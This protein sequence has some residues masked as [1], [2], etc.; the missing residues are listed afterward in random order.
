MQ[1]QTIKR[2]VGLIARTGIGNLSNNRVFE[3]GRRVADLGKAINSTGSRKA[4][5]NPLDS[6]QRTRQPVSVSQEEAILRKIRSV[7]SDPLQESNSQIIK[8]TSRWLYIT[9]HRR[10]QHYRIERFGYHTN[11]AERSKVINLAGLGAGGHKNNWDPGCYVIISELKESCRPVQHRHHDVEQNNVGLPIGG[12][13][14]GLLAGAAASRRKSSVKA[15]RQFHDLADIGLVIDM[16][17]TN[18]VHA[19]SLQAARV[20][21]SIDLG[22]LT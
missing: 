19:T 1:N 2:K 9:T 13:C 14:K 8:R 18:C 20:E 3:C 17:N 11:G 15:K 21:A 6:I 5:R 10:C 16:E 12:N 22:R 4:M 7:L